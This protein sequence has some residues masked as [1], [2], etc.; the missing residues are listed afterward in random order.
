MHMVKNI[1]KL[2][3]SILK[4]KFQF[5]YL[6]SLGHQLPSLE[7]TTATK[8]SGILLYIGVCIYTIYIFMYKYTFIFCLHKN[9]YI[10]HICIYF[11][12]H[13]NGSILYTESCTLLFPSLYILDMVPQQYIWCYLIILR[14]SEY[15][16]EQIY[17]NYLTTILLIYVQVVSRLLK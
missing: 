12:N 14:A 6:C 7:A 17:H 5:P 9:I 10:L 13:T 15:S 3:N 2:P 11:L 4:K 1:Q 8:L 16:I